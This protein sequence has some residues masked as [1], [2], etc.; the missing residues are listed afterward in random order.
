MDSVPQFGHILGGLID[1]SS[2]TFVG[3]FSI[4]QDHEPSPYC[5]KACGPRKPSQ[6]VATGNTTYKP[7]LLNAYAPS[8]SEHVAR[9]K[10]YASGDG[11]QVKT[12]RLTYES[13]HAAPGSAR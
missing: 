2:E 13:N 10:T 7:N 9:P 11:K 6:R 1:G 12:Q 8:L 3:A 4:G 5:Y